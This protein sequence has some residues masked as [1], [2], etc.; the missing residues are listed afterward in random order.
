MVEDEIIKTDTIPIIPEPAGPLPPG[1][2]P[3][4][5]LKKP[6]P[7][8]AIVKILATIV[9]IVLVAGL[10]FGRGNKKKQVIVTPSPS[11][12]ID[13]SRYDDDPDDDKVPSF[14]EVKTG[15]NP[16]SSEVEECFK[17]RC[18]VPSIQEVNRKPRNV[19]ILL[20]SSG[21]MEQKVGGVTKMESA[22]QAIAEYMKKAESLPLTRVG[23]VVYGHKGSNQQKDKEVSCKSA[24][25]VA[26]LG[27]LTGAEV[28]TLLANISPVG[29]TPI[30]L[31]LSTAEESIK[32]SVE[33][34]KK[35]KTPTEEAVNEVVIISD[36]IET[37]D[38][39][40]V[41]AAKNLAGSAEKV[42][43][44]VIGFAVGDSEGGELRK[45]AEAGGGTY[46]TAP[47]I[48]ELKVAM[49]LQWENY[50]RKTREAACDK[51]GAKLYYACIDRAI[52]LVKSWVSAELSRDPRQLSYQEKLKID[53]LRWV[54]PSYMRGK[55]DDGNGSSYIPP[56]EQ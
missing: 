17:N 35:S 39:N 28:P 26:P 19:M 10:I 44:H 52:A 41:E 54:V 51:V 21:S 20:D 13:L 25:V 5:I 23:L 16:N 15:L 27:K 45:I 40:P 9:V 50:V 12:A 8:M 48:D 38:T 3:P 4:L 29:W 37:C 53:R 32:K 6:T 46:A 43:V 14:V 7:L 22:K 18:N 47:S 33:E 36:G 1:T 2:L 11:P 55:L 30:G 24:E 31:A 42:T 34:N 49:D 56:S